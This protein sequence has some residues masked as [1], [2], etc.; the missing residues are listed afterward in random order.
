MFSEI[1]LLLLTVVFGTIA[2]FISSTP[3]GPINLLVAEHCLH[4][5]KFNLRYFLSGVLAADVLCAFIAFWGFHTVITDLQ[6]EQ[7]I[8][9]VGA[10]LI[11]VLGVLSLLAVFKTSMTSISEEK[12][13]ELTEKFQRRKSKYWAA[14]QG[15]LMCGAN[16]GFLLY[17]LYVASLQ[18]S[19]LEKFGVANA[20]NVEVLIALL[21]GV[22]V[23]D[24]IWF[25]LFVKLLN[26]GA[27]KMG[28]KM[29]RWVRIGISI[30]LILMGAYF[31]LTQVSAFLY[32]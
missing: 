18:G 2:G 4:Q 10:L 31:L 16:P 22:I 21:F 29:I 9:L 6:I 32:S 11:V 3:L 20:D 17:W 12:N 8:I 30:L 27:K 5:R 28:L 19:F 23:G 7:Y 13:Q 24:V 1:V 25:G 14:I 15:A 26:Y